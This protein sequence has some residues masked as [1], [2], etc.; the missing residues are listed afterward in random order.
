VCGA[1][2]KWNIKIAFY[3]QTVFPAVLFSTVQSFLP[4]TLP[5]GKLFGSRLKD[6]NL[7]HEQSLISLL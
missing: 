4:Q 2:V 5:L 6:K 1:V 7:Y 3:Y